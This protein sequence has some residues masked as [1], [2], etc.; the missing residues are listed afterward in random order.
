MSEV[1]RSE[2]VR[3]GVTLPSKAVWREY[4]KRLTRRMCDQCFEREGTVQRGDSQ[5]CPTCASKKP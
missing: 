1:R 4:R 2:T 3:R 5:L